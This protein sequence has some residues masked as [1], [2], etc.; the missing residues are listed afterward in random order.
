VQYLVDAI[1]LTH[2][3]LELLETYSKGKP[4][5]IKTNRVVQKKKKNKEARKG[6]GGII[7]S[8]DEE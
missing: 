5:K 8:D 7:S 4:M 2:L 3:V 6:A 1:E